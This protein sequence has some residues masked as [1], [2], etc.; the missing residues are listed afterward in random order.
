MSLKKIWNSLCGRPNQSEATSGSAVT[1]PA[2]N[3][4]ATSGS[5]TTV[6]PVKTARTPAMVQAAEVKTQTPEIS[7]PRRGVLS[8]LSRGEHDSLLKMIAQARP[9]SVLEIGIGDGSRMPAIS[10]MFTQSGV[11]PGAMKTIVI[12]QFE[13]G[14]SE[15]TMRD[16]HRQLAGLAIRPVIFPESVGRGLVSVAHRF[17]LI[18]VVMVDAAVRSAAAEELATYLIKVSH[19]HTLVLHQENGKWIAS[20]SG[21]RR[22]RAA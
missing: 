9:S 15:I 13:L 22:S 12:D 3:T 7:P 4:P 20:K 21:Q 10:A 6:S 1:S 19:E 14:G 18:D 2:T 5:A 8:M 11:S 17:G 16:Y